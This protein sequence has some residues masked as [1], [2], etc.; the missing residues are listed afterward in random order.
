[1]HIYWKTITL[2]RSTTY[3]R[4]YYQRHFTLL[5]SFTG[6]I[7]VLNHKRPGLAE[8]VR[9]GNSLEAIVGCE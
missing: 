3:D 5:T 2:D 6:Q 1:M 7:L 4:L 9:L 8:S